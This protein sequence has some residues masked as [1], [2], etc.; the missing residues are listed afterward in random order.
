MAAARRR[1]HE[2]AQVLLVPVTAI[3]AFVAAIPGSL[4]LVDWQAGR[5][6]R[7]RRPPQEVPPKPSAPHEPCA[8]CPRR[9]RLEGCT[10]PGA[11]PPPT[12][13]RPPETQSHTGE[14]VAA[15]ATGVGVLAY[16]V[17]GERT[18]PV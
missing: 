12:G 17:D 11:E 15:A 9:S 10:D 14:H 16:V 4:R 1:A 18:Y 3:L 6:G 7:T 2:A 8:D 5:A 13:E